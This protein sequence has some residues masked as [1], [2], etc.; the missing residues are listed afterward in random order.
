MK[1]MKIGGRVCGKDEVP[2]AGVRRSGMAPRDERRGNAGLHP[3][4]EADQSVPPV[5]KDA[6]KLRDKR[7]GPTRR[8]SI[9]G[10]LCVAKTHRSDTVGRNLAEYRE[11]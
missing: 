11:G 1:Q 10:T 4:D 6:E 8:A 2:D 7:P 9:S 3:C 5:A